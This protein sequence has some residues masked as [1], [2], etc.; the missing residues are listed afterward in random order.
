MKRQER[1][2]DANKGIATN[3]NVALRLLLL[4]VAIMVL[5]TLGSAV[6]YGDDG[7]A[8]AAVAEQSDQSSQVIFDLLNPLAAFDPDPVCGIHWFMVIGIVVTLAYGVG[9]VAHRLRSASQVRAAQEE[10]QGIVQEAE[11]ASS[12]PS[13]AMVHNA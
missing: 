1:S 7:A 4:V 10:A 11:E 2:I 5:F 13:S 8:A 3:F 9:V 12:A 6:A